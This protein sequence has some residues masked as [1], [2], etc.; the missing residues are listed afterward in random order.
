MPAADDK[1][2]ENEVSG[3]IF[4]TKRIMAN[5]LIPDDVKRF[6]NEKIDSVAELEGLLL[7]RRKREIEWTAETLS[8]ELYTNREQAGKV[9]TAL[10]LL[11]F[12][13]VRAVNKKPKYQYQPVSAELGMLADRIDE[14]YSKY[15]I[16]VTNLI[17]SKPP[18]KIQKFADAFR[19][20]KQE[21][22]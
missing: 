1:E 18:N 9:L 11:G 19:F 4:Y 3:K 21:D 16:P 22:E 10:H 17:H 15:L 7:L 8:Q 20:R 6:I 12:L 2:N 13:A 14:V 5:D